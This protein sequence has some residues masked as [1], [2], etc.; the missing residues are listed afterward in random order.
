MT[1]RQD[2]R[3]DLMSSAGS[4][5]R[6]DFLKKSSMAAAFGAAAAA[7]GADFGLARAAE[8]VTVNG[9]SGTVLG[10]TGLKVTRIS[11]GGM[12]FTD[13]AIL[14]RV[15]DQGINLIHTAP[16]Y[17]NGKSME[18]FGKAFKQNKSLRS[19]V[20][21]A[22][23]E[24][25]EDLDPCLKVLNTDY[26]DILVPP[27]ERLDLINDPTIPENFQK[28]KKAGKCGFMGYACHDNMTE[29]LNRS[30]ELGYFDVTLMAYSNAKDPGF[31]AAA[32]T[33]REAGI[34]IMTMKG[35]PKEIARKSD[36]FNLDTAAS[37][38]GTMV[39]PQHANTVL[40]SMSSFQMID[41]YHEILETKLTYHNQEL[42][43]RYWAGQMGSYCSMCGNCTG[44]CPQGVRISDVIRY[45]MYRKDYQLTEYARQEYAALP[46]GCDGSFCR[47]CGLCEGICTRKLPVREMLREAHSLLA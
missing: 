5:N 37:L 12:L 38:C 4:I 31:L 8:K 36:G 33:A 24:R 2:Y 42:E 21:I 30:R 28:A 18:A 40:A 45:R 46:Q 47:E 29:V 1:E 7:L 44:I 25:P 6:R 13:P 43:D 26:V 3:F 39:G 27:L 17:T 35:L 22:L 41:N 19:K 16:G 34:G 14:L 23:K 20:V 9:L 32:K 15:I 11:F 10:R